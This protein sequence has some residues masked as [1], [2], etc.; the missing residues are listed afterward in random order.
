MPFLGKWMEIIMLSKIRLRN[1]NITFFS[2][3][4]NLDFLKRHES[5]RGPVRG[6]ERQRKQSR[7]NRIKIFYVKITHSK[8]TKD[9]FK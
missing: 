8:C 9:F 5:R 6:G 2:H 1:T 4:W 3:M 7:L